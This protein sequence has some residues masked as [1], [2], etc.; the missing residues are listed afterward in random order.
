L[1]AEKFL[2]FIG[3][4][5][6]LLVEAL[7]FAHEE[8]GGPRSAP[9]LDLSSDKGLGDHIGEACGNDRISIPVR[10]R[11]EITE[12]PVVRGRAI[13][14]MAGAGSPSMPLGIPDNDNFPAPGN[15]G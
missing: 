1:A 7:P 12:S 14:V 13:A 5:F 9:E 3:A 10:V 2:K 6:D 8:L 4:V 15:P 11:R